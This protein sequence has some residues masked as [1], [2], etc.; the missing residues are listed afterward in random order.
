M[1]DF[2]Y[3][4]R[5]E[6]E[7]INSEWKGECT[8]DIDTLMREGCGCGA[9]KREQGKEEPPPPPDPS[10]EVPSPPPDAFIWA[11]GGQI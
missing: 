5:R 1:C 8:C 10:D 6:Q 9:F 3:T 7:T 11:V 2:G 4:I